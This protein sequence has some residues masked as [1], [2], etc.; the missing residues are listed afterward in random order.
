MCQTG[1][2]KDMPV[3]WDWSKVTSENNASSWKFVPI[4]SQHHNGLPEAMVKA[5]K[6]S[7]TQTLSSGIVLAYDKLVTLLARIACSINSHPLGLQNTANTSQQEE[8][9]CL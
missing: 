3:K 2:E 5:V 4:G 8:D 1:A 9:I 7:L 6:K